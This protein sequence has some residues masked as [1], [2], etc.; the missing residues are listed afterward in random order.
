MSHKIIFSRGLSESRRRALLVSSLT[1]NQRILILL[2]YLIHPFEICS[3]TSIYIMFSVCVPAHLHVYGGY[4][5]SGRTIFK[6][7]PGPCN[8]K[9]WYP[10]STRARCLYVRTRT[11]T[12][13]LCDDTRSKARS[14][15]I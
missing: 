15:G 9:F 8:L 6:P 4:R 1:A 7:E 11:R 2:I 10:S 3:A 5:P 14:R 13:L 12:R